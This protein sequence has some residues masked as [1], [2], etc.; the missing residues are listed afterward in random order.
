M[1]RDLL[2]ARAFAVAALAG[3]LLAAGLAANGVQADQHTVDNDPDLNR[4]ESSEVQVSEDELERFADA[5][6]A[7]EEVGAR[8]QSD[9]EEAESPEEMQELQDEVLAAQTEAI[10]AEGMSLGRFSR[11]F[12]AI[13][14]DQELS[15]RFRALLEERD[16]PDMN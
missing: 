1:T 12:N 8:R 14:T 11:I 2:R 5:F 7:A 10:E 13:Q 16:R 4:E 6:V 15:E 9:F 3:G